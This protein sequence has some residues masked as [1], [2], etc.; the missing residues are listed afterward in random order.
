MSELLQLR[1]LICSLLLHDQNSNTAHITPVACRRD[2]AISGAVLDKDN[3]SRY[4]GNAGLPLT[5][6]PVV[7]EGRS[8]KANSTRLRTETDQTGLT[9]QP[10]SR[11]FLR[12][13]FLSVPN[14][15]TSSKN[16]VE[17]E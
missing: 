13:L 15:M 2:M 12:M 14:T 4:Y 9:F 10:H 7:V 8:A 6:C 5:L 17:R 16:R 1:L 11:D 3:P